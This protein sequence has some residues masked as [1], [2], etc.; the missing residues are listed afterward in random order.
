MLTGTGDHPAPCG[1]AP[2]HQGPPGD[3]D[4][5]EIVEATHGT[6]NSPLAARQQADGGSPGSVSSISQPHG[7]DVD[8]PPEP[9]TPTTRTDFFNV[10]TPQPQ[11]SE[12]EE[13]KSELKAVT[14]QTAYLVESYRNM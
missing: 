8:A 14:S 6:V 10:G 4:R 7:R 5:A 12:V 13:M 1:N 3:R 11:R 9:V 2:G